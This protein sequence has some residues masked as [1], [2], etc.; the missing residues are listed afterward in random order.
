MIQA[1]AVVGTLLYAA[2]QYRAFIGTERIKNT[3]PFV[4]AYWEANPAPNDAQ[5][6]LA[7]T[8]A[9][10]G[11]WPGTQDEKYRV[12]RDAT[13]KY[14]VLHNFLD[15]IDDAYQRNVV[16]RDY[17][18]SR[19]YKVISDGVEQVERWQ[20]TIRQDIPRPTMW[21]RLSAAVDEFKKKHPE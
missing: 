6:W 4:R 2:I 16:D 11:E 8:N 14:V 12:L 21:A 17:L 3:F 19:L 10:Y 18:M 5:A 7:I 1:V 15:E 20:E 9:N 13:Y